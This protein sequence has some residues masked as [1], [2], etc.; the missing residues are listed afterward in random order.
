M[1]EIEALVVGEKRVGAVLEEQIDDVVMA[2]FR[3]PEDRCSDGV[4][5][6]RV[7]TRAVLYQEMA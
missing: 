5:T 2:S 6:L 7:Y 4:S 1:Q 3:G